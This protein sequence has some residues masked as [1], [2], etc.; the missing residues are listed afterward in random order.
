MIYFVLIF[1][2]FI[3]STTHLIAQDVTQHVDPRIVLIFRGVIA[4][5]A[6]LAIIFFTR[7][8]DKKG[9]PP[10]A[11]EDRWRLILLGALNV[12]INQFLYLEGVGLTSP[13]NSALLYA[14]TPLFVFL[15]TLAVHRE[16]AS[17]KK[18]AG[19]L[20]AFFGVTLI[21]I[22][23]GADLHPT[24]M[25]GNVLVF[26][27][28]IAWSA[29]TFL[30]K[31]LVERY[32]ALRVTGLNMAIGTLLYLP[33]GLLLSDLHSIP[34]IAQADWLRIVYLGIMASVVN[35]LLWFYALGKLETSKVAIFQNLQPVFTVIMALILGR[36]IL[37]G[38]FT[39]GSLMALVGVTLVQL[40]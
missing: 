8:N 30:G 12:P 5:I 10:I 14:M 4:S 11:R 13:A 9:R 24:Y 35:Y 32:G 33:I 6:L 36:A 27:A 23:H 40:A 34:V 7:N 20:V 38:Q 29:Y 31:P 37:T 17:W 25:K 22:E 15:L 39:A 19:I 21:M 1:Q 2:Q 26:V 18:W 3:A 16:R 28:V